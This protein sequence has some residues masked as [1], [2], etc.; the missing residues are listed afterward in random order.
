MR[1]P[2]AITV[3]APHC[4]RS[5]P[6]FSAHEARV[7]AQGIEQSDAR[8]ELQRITAAIHVQGDGPG[9]DSLRSPCGRG[10]GCLGL[11][12]KVRCRTDSGGGRGRL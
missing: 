7:L 4:P 11:R 6:F 1:R 8:L 2:L 3:H 10:D 5:Q 9:R 12:A